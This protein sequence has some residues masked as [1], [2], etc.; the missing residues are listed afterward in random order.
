MAEFPQLKG[1]AVSGKVKIWS[2]RVIEYNSQGIIETTHGYEDGKMQIAQK[3]ISEGKNIGKRN[4][5][6]PLQQAIQEA[7]SA[8]IKKKE[9]GYSSIDDN[10]ENEEKQEK[11]EKQEQ[12]NEEKQEPELKGRGKGHNNLVPGPMLA[13]DYMK[14]GKS[15]VY[16]CFAQKKYDG[17]R[18]IAI[19]GQGLFSRLKKKFPHM[20]HIIDEINKLSPYTIL[21]GELYSDKLTFQEIIG[22]VKRETLKKGDAEK[23]L[24]IK[25]HVYDILND[26]T[27]HTRYVSLQQMFKQHKFKHLMLVNS[28][29]CESE[30]HMKDLHAQY[31][32]EGFEGIMLRNRNG[33]YS[34]HRSVDLQKYKEFFDMECEITDF[35]QGE[36]LE[37]GCV[38]W[39]CKTPEGKQFMCRPRGSREQRQEMFNDGATY[40][41][42][43]LTVRYQE[44]TDDGLLRFPVGIAIRDYEGDILSP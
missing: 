13:H 8:W 38:V 35:K 23:Q 16:P 1:N 10:D 43:M 40:I 21:D 29:V 7:K 25:F 11:Q 31:V 34:N 6:T 9:S 12:E 4:E 14:R 27:Y 18:C 19:P 41:G 36:G 24:Q 26:S 15:I 20:E 22:L 28:D 3:I 44:K 30:V 32:A 42:K 33:N 5:T 2:I 37:E 39:M 17:V